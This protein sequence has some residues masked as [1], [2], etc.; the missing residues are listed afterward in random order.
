[1]TILPNILG[2]VEKL[3]YADHDVADRDKFPEFEPQVYMERK[4]IS[5]SGVPILEPK[6]WITG[7]YNTRIMNLLEILILDEARM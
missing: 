7:L 3:R 2:C 1:V 4:G 6:Q 5:V